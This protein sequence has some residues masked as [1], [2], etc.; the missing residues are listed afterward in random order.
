MTKKIAPFHDHALDL[1]ALLEDEKAELI[2]ALRELLKCVEE[3]HDR[4]EEAK[5]AG[6]P[7]ARRVGK[8]I[9]N[10]DAVLRKH[11]RRA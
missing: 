2:G 10:A 5:E 8:C 7:V 3:L 4:S 6:N 1:F 9:D 11:S